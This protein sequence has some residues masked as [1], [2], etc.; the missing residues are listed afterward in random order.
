MLIRIQ[1][2]SLVLATIVTSFK[3]FMNVSEDADLEL[4]EVA[5]GGDMHE[6]DEDDRIA[7][8]EDAA[9]NGTP[10]QALPIG[11]TRVQASQKVQAPAA[12]TQ[13]KKKKVVADSWADEDAESS[14]PSDWD[15]DDSDG[16]ATV[17][18]TKATSVTT[19]GAPAW[20]EE[21]GEGLR[22]VALAFEALKKAFDDKFKK[23]WA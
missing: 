4:V 16:D 10:K 22:K 19:T 3:N 1:D 14:E 11:Q 9:A 23:M 18:S 8:V 21:S 5:G 20:D 13:K 17:A 6:L 7:R 12:T 2:F 15:A